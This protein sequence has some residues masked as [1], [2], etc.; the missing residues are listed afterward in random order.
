VIGIGAVLTLLGCIFA[1]V[2]IGALIWVGIKAL[3]WML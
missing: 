3:G 2:V 1:T